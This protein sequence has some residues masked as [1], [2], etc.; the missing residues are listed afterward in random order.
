MEI[1]GIYLSPSS[2]KAPNVKI[3]QLAYAAIG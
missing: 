3:K 1:V 2:I